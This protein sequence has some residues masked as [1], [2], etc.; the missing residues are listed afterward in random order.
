MASNGCLTTL[1]MDDRMF[2]IL[3]AILDDLSVNLYGCRVP[4]IVVRVAAGDP[5]VPH[6]S[7]D[8][9]TEGEHRSAGC[10]ENSFV[11][12]IESL[13]NPIFNATIGCAKRIELAHLKASLKDFACD[14]LFEH[15]GLR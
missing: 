11:D 1:P 15:D 4:E 14:N 3:R 6:S 2:R 13:T 10:S 12:G 7:C 9:A 5:T 8:V